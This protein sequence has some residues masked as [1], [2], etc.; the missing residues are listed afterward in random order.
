M[1]NSKENLKY[2]KDCVNAKKK[3]E[4][5]ALWFCGKHRRFITEHSCVSALVDKDCKDY[6]EVTK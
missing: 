6:Q 3:L 4:H 1:S 5:D 2:C